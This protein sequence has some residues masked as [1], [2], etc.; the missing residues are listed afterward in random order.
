[1]KKLIHCAVCK[2]EFTVEELRW[3]P[4]KDGKKRPVCSECYSTHITELL[5][6]LSQVGQPTLEVKTNGTHP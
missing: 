3:A 2:H 6:A 4:C 1:V 5:T